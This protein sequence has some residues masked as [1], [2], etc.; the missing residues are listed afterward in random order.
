ME[1]TMK[2]SGTCA[3]AADIEIDGGVVKRVAFHGGCDGNLQAISKLV[4]GMKIDDVANMLEGIK[5]GRKPTS[6]PDQLAKAIREMM[7]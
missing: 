4:V 3:S 7:N 6:C 5:C 2:L 1:K